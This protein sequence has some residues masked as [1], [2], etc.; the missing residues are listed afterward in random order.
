MLVNGKR[1]PLITAAAHAAA[2]AVMLIVVLAGRP[3]EAQVDATFDAQNYK[4]GPSPL[5]LLAVERGETPGHLGFGL[6]LAFDYS[7]DPLVLSERVEDRWVESAKLVE[8]RLQANLTGVI[9]VLRFLQFGLRVPAVLYQSGESAPDPAVG[10]DAVE[11][12]AFGDIDLCAKAVL[13]RR[14]KDIVGLGLAVSLGVPSGGKKRFA[15]DGGVTAAPSLILDLDFHIVSFAVNFGYRYR[16]GGEILDLEVGQELFA[17][18]ALGVAI[19]SFT[20]MGQMMW[21]GSLAKSGDE[22]H[23][24]VEFTGGLRY[25]LKGHWAFTVGA[26]S[27]VTEGY[28]APDLRVLASIGYISRPAAKPGD[29]DSDGILDDMDKCPDKA[30]DMDGFQDEDGCPDKDHDGDGI[31]DKKDKCPE[32]PEDM[33]GFEDKDGCEERDNDGDTIPDAHDDCPDEAETINGVEDG[34]GCPEPDSDS[35]GIIDAEDACPDKAEDEDGFGDDDGCPEIDND[36]DGILDADDGCPIEPETFNNVEDEDGCPDKARIL[37]CQI[38]IKEKVQ[39]KTGSA[40]LLSAS[41][42]LLDEVAGILKANPQLGL[43]RIEG[44]TDDKG[45]DESNLKLSQER[46]ESVLAYLVEKGVDKARLKAVGLGETKPI[47]DNKSVEGKG[48]NRRVEFHI[49]ECK[50]KTE[51]VE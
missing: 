8:H 41:Y 37:G 20:V 49:E 35:D 45:S 33:D 43:I 12:A 10:L 6:Q 14:L 4:P 34:D 36:G 30:E 25:L 13:P 44:H 9:G 50:E 29:R 24:P 5:D 17:S 51:A 46:A 31:P 28:G 19:K 47:A 16:D 2:W 7:H 26:G 21:R 15:G 42:D 3:A 32:E 40:K 11:A 1:R 27:S 38:S 48:K 23:N 18:A 39:F 22:N